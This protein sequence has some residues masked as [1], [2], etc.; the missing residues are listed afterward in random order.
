MRQWSGAGA[1]MSSMFETYSYWGGLYSFESLLMKCYTTNHK[2]ASSLLKDF[3]FF[4]SFR[5]SEESL[6]PCWLC[7]ILLLCND[8][9]SVFFLKKTL[10]KWL[11][12][13]SN[14]LFTVY[15]WV[16]VLWQVWLVNFFC[17]CQKETDCFI[18]FIFRLTKSQP[19]DMLLYLCTSILK[20]TQL[21]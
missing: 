19:V 16:S 13:G 7:I 12:L 1:L 15:C 9:V 10:Y 17:C 2:P 18:K 4:F 21:G 3:V 14:R 6:L 20:E 8:S 5:F 11:G